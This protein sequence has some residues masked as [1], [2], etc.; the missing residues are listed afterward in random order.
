MKDLIKLFNYN[1][2]SNKK[3]QPKII[4]PKI[5]E[6]KKKKSKTEPLTLSQ[7]KSV[8]KRNNL[9]VFKVKQNEIEKK[10]IKDIQMK[11]I[12]EIQM[13]NIQEIKKKEQK[14]FIRIKYYI[15]NFL[16]IKYNIKVDDK[17]K[18]F[19]QDGIFFYKGPNET[20]KDFPYQHG[21]L[22]PGWWWGDNYLFT[23]N[24]PCLTNS[25]D[26]Y[27]SDELPVLTKVRIINKKLNGILVKFEYG[28]NWKHLE[29]FNDNINFEDKI[30]D[31]CWRGNHITGLWKVS[32]RRT[33]ISKYY[34]KYNVGYYPRNNDDYCKNNSDMFKDYMTKEDQLKYKYL[35][36]IEGND[37]AGS[38]KW[39]LASNSVILMTKPIIEGWLMEG[40]LEPYVHYVPLK[41]DFSDLEEI[42]EWCNNNQNKCKEISNNGKKWME[43][44]KNTEDEKFLHNFILKHY[45]DNVNLS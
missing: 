44:F 37:I 29:N 18:I 41:N 10:K 27:Y 42:I 33:F 30:N 12:Q 32:N 38:L 9:L 26:G 43:Q 13:K 6:L 20:V 16:N 25:A 15:G 11:N 2:N 31:I 4:Q 24:I 34:N 35:I 7:N 8:T 1:N 3:I 5:P 21:T 22:S 36:S 19:N 45:V 39:Q 28:Y 14:L 23:V 40:L 17:Y